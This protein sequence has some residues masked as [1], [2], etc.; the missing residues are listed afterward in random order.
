MATTRNG[1]GLGTE[2]HIHSRIFRKPSRILIK[3]AARE[4]ALKST[5]SV[6]ALETEYLPS[7]TPNPT[8]TASQDRLF[9][10]SRARA[11][12]APLESR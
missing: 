9:D 2:F 12:I 4:K 3:A 11:R 7:I 10:P 8:L 6:S 1:N 5:L